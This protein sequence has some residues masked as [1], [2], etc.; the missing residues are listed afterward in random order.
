M[1]AC[2]QTHIDFDRRR[3]SANYQPPALWLAT[4]TPFR[5]HNIASSVALCVTYA[6]ASVIIAFSGAATICADLWHTYVSRPLWPWIWWTSSVVSLDEMYLW[7][8]LGPVQLKTLCPTRRLT[9]RSMWTQTGITPSERLGVWRLVQP[10]RV[11]LTVPT[12]LVRIV[13]LACHQRFCKKYISMRIHYND[14][15][16]IPGPLPSPQFKWRK[17]CQ[18]I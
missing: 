16:K 7:N 15:T 1:S 6:R 11:L 5:T 9:A 2:D 14:S 8:R 17:R 4:G 10:I 3:S 18:H 13:M 12:P